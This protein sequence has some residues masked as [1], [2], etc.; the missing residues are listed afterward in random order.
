MAGLLTGRLCEIPIAVAGSGGHGRAGEESNMFGLGTTE[1]II[2]LVIVMVVFGAT[3]LPALGRGLG[4]GMR[5]FRNALR[6]DT[7][8]DSKEANLEKTSESA[9]KERKDG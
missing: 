3:R 4:S 5:N 8:D 1:L 9:E 2:I 6:G 7:D